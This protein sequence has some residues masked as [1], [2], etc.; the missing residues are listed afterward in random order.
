MQTSRG[1]RERFVARANIASLEQF[2]KDLESIDIEVMSPI[3][4]A[5]HRTIGLRNFLADF[6]LPLWFLPGYLLI[7]AYGV[8]IRTVALGLAAYLTVAVALTPARHKRKGY[9][10]I[11]GERTAAEWL[12]VG[13]G[14][15][16]RAVLAWAGIWLAYAG[17]NRCD[18]GRWLV[19]LALDLGALATLLVAHVPAHIAERAARRRRTVRFSTETPAD[20]VLLLRSFADD[21]IRVTANFNDLSLASPFF[22]GALPSRFEELVSWSLFTSGS[23]VAIG[24]PGEPLPE[25]GAAR[26]YWP[27]DRWQDAVQYTAH[28]AERIVMVGGLT[29]GLAWEIDK[30]RR[31]GL[32][33]KVLV[34]LP[35]DTPQHSVRRL[36]RVLS[37]LGIEDFPLASYHPYFVVGIS[38]STATGDLTPV[39]H[40]ALGR[41]ALEYLAALTIHRVLVRDSSKMA[42]KV[43]AFVATE[44]RE[45]E[46][47][48][49]EQR[50]PNVLARAISEPVDRKSP[51]PKAESSRGP[52]PF[53]LH[54]QRSLEAARS[55]AV[56]RG[57]SAITPGHFLLGLIATA[58]S[59]FESLT[60]ISAGWAAQQ[61]ISTFTV[62]NRVRATSAEFDADM[63]GILRSAEGEARRMGSSEI[64]TSHLVLAAHQH[65]KGAIAK[66]IPFFALSLDQAR[67]IA[68]N[69]I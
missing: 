18:H 35:P 34:L 31:W 12:L 39:V 64:L 23:L 37:D 50:I 21:N 5:V 45:H 26:T 16:A 49:P 48:P 57:A 36:E 2:T 60:S 6:V 59:D 52:T 29:Q 69:V 40:T 17:M 61:I 66:A 58:A 10:P 7:R 11:G 27:D 20:S 41:T 19:G 63:P 44:L 22:D 38:F 42:E 3:D 30:L 14:L 24:R 15:V 51:A 65:R 46:I 62:N 25:L 43:Q 68:S 13:P 33:Q 32:L 8:P 53:S 54:A 9:Q 28:R 4:R 1:E 56:S 47:E 55:E 67:A